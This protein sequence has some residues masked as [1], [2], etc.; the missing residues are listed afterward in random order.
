MGLPVLILGDSGTGK[1]ASMRNLDPAKTSVINVIGKRLPFKNEFTTFTCRDIDV[2]MQ[3]A[4]PKI[5]TPVMVIDDF[6]YLI[7][8]L[9]LRHSY[10]ADKYRD[11]Y[12]V[13]KEIGAKIYDLINELNTTVPENTICYLTMHLDR[14][15]TGSLMPATVGKLLNEK[16]NLVGMFTIVLMSMCDA[17][18]Y[19]FVTNQTPPTKSPMGMFESEKIP[20][21]LKAVDDAIREFWGI[22]V[23]RKD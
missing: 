8:D 9:F 16:I 5:K 7:T 12:E 18:G 2:V 19:W 21:D 22:G 4:I 14:D 3:K 11:Q 23:D 13:Y 6:G 17:D 1:S 20:N 15:A 10:G